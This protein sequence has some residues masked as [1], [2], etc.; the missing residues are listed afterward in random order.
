MV[1]LSEGDQVEESLQVT[2]HFGFCPWGLDV[3]EA[4]EELTRKSEFGT[5]APTYG[6]AV[7]VNH[8]FIALAADREELFC[9]W[10]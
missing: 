2:H 10:L 3:P 8:W 9:G 4:S 1:T 6:L 7:C 5:R